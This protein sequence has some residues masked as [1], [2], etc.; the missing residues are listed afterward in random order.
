MKLSKLIKKYRQDNNLSQT[1]L[2]NKLYVSKQAISKW[3]TDKGLPDISLYPV[4]SEILNV[5]ID[6]LMGKEKPIEKAKSKKLLWIICSL[7]LVLCVV[8]AITYKESNQAEANLEEHIQETEENLNISL[9][10]IKLYEYNDFT[11]WKVYN[12]SY[13]SNMYYFIFK[14]E[15]IV[16]DESWAEKLDDELIGYIPINVR[17]YTNTC[18]YFKLLN[19]TTGDVNKAPTFTEKN[20]KCEFTLYCLQIVNKRLIVINFNAEVK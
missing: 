12:N 18:D 11:T 15:I 19:K 9:P 2:A 8:L 13:P 3:E 7:T 5:S 10:E 6:E 4:L 14:D 1:D 20:E 17:E 16:V